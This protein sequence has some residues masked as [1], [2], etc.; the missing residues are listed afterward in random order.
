MSEPAARANSPVP[1]SPLAL[2]LI[3]LLGTAWSTIYTEPAAED[4]SY[5]LRIRP[6]P[7]ALGEWRM[8]AALM[9]RNAWGQRHVFT[10]LHAFRWPGHVADL[11][12]LH[13]PTHIAHRRAKERFATFLAAKGHLRRAPEIALRQA[14]C[15]EF[16]HNVALVITCP[17][18]LTPLIVDTARSYA[19]EL[20]MVAYSCSL[21][22]LHIAR[23]KH[24]QEDRT[25]ELN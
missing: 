15:A 10:G 4:A 21:W 19:S 9:A 5:P 11:E 25:S 13:T 22:P 8:A 3:G 7:L 20:P 14:L 18:D 6:Y 12:A 24:L 1:M 23:V 16:R 17:Q 2:N